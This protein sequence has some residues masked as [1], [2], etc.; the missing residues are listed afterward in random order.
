[1][2]SRRFNALRLAGLL[3]LAA[4][5]Q[6]AEPRVQP[7]R[8]AVAAEADRGELCLDVA[9]T[10]ACWGG[11]C[12]EAGCVVP[13]V[14][15]KLL[16]PP[17]GFRCAGTG[18]ARTCEARAEQ[19]GPFRCADGRCVQE[20]PR[21]PDNG[22]WDCVEIDGAVYCRKL[23]E[24]AGV[25]AGPLDPAFVCGPRPRSGELVCVDFAPDPPPMPEPHR[26]AV[27]NRA[28]LPERVCEPRP[29]PRLGRTCAADA[30]CD[31]STR[32]VQ[33]RCLPAWPRPGCWLDKDCAPGVCKLGSCR[34][35]A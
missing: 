23:A 9:D 1:V 32:C 31:A 19:A 12:G 33:G 25:Q 6:Q 20:R 28:G 35:G 21:F 24:A 7:A 26:C 11:A 22:E 15:P 17:S 18:R 10:R 2:V 29:S 34:E 13:V 30:P 27:R 8:V 14:Q 4:C 3:W 5:G 16:T